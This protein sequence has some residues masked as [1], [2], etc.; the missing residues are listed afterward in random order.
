MSRLVQILEGLPILGP[1]HSRLGSELTDKAAVA[2]FVAQNGSFAAYQK[3]GIGAL[4]VLA[5]N[6]PQ[7]GEIVKRI[8][9]QL[10]H[11]PDGVDAGTDP[12]VQKLFTSLDNWL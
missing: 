4:E 8:Q 10:L 1:Q 5:G 2:T 3:F 12:G 6:S 9:N 11:T 7:V